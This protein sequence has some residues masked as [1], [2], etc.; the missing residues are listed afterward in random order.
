MS[1]NNRIPSLNALRAFEAA[2]RHLSFGAAATELF[3][4][5]AAIS[6][7]I[8]GLEEQ[9]EQQLFHRVQ[10]RVELTE[11]GRL[12]L[13]ELR[14][15]FDLIERSI[16]RLNESKEGKSLMVSAS[17]ALT[18]KWLLPRLHEFHQRHPDI[19]IHLDTNPLPP[20]LSKSEVDLAIV[21]GT[22]KYAGLE[23]TPLKVG[24]REIV[25]PVCSPELLRRRTKRKIGRGLGDL[26]L[27]HYDDPALEG[28]LPDWQTWLNAAGIHGVDAKRG[29]R[30]NNQLLMI[31]AAIRGQGVALG[32][33]FVV[34]DDLESGRL[35][36]PIEH[37]CISKHNYYI[38]HRRQHKPEATAKFSEW[39]TEAADQTELP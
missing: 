9:L 12:L 29:A 7:Q 39:L 26:P 5:P 32:C 23:A 35:I 34:A 19:E 18:A 37:P 27:L 2:A 24:L 36:R 11:A 1:K 13:P 8:K 4:T 33:R 17:S 21:F 22:G 28:I 16:T 15:A 31:E 30:F 25:V 38:V 3:V 14:E 10:R 6:H 20:D